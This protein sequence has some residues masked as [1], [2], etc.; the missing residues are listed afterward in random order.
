MDWTEKQTCIKCNEGGKVLVCSDNGCPLAVHEKCMRY[1]ARFDDMGNFYCSYCSYKRAIMES[2]KARKKAMLAKKALSVFLDKG[3]TG[4]DQQKQKSERVKRKEPNTST[5]AGDTTHDDTVNRMD[6]VEV[7]NHCIQIEEDLQEERFNPECTTS[8]LPCKRAEASS[9]NERNDVVLSRCGDNATLDDRDQHKIVLEQQVHPKP[10]IACGSG[11]VCCRE[12]K[13]G[14]QFEILQV[15]KRVKAEHPKQVDDH[16]HERVVEDELQAEPLSASPVEEDP[17]L[18]GTLHITTEGKQNNAEVFK[19]NEGRMAKEEEMQ[20]QAQETTVSSISSS[21][22]NPATQVHAKASDSFCRDTGTVSTH[23]R[24]VKQKSPNV[25]HPKNV[26]PPRRTSRK[27][28]F[29]LNTTTE[30]NEKIIQTSKSGKFQ[31]PSERL[32]NPAFPSGRRKKLPWTDEEEEMLREGVQK[33]STTV[34]KNLPWRKI[35]EFGHH[36][37]DRTR[38]PVDLKDKWRNILVKGCSRK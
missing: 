21:G 10:I 14:H 31:E 15:V 17:T 22:G 13:T 1:S 35:L 24:H 37:F 29:E 18:D 30:H 36:V 19:E 38:T 26:V 8:I 2:C 23:R 7:H 20:E 34:N 4:G 33:F 16:Q 25:V 12:E 32:R 27:L 28:S 5:I 11:G 9:V 3:M 6:G